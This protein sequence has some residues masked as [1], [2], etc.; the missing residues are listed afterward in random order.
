MALSRKHYKAI[1]NAIKQSSTSYSRNKINKVVLIDELSSIFI[2]DNGLFS[3]SK[4]IDA[5]NGD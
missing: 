5:C 4:F 1:A 2:S 3:R